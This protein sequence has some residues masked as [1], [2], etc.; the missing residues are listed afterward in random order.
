M[1]SQ[2][3]RT[4]TLQ[5]QS[6]DGY[7]PHPGSVVIEAFK[8]LQ[9]KVKS[10]EEERYQACSLRDELKSK[11]AMQKRDQHLVRSKTEYEAAE[12]LIHVRS[13]AEQTKRE[14]EELE[15]RVRTTQEVQDSI[16]RKLS[17]QRGLVSSLQED[18]DRNRSRI[19]AAEKQNLLL[20]R[21][22]KV[23]SLR[24]S[25]LDFVK[26]H[27]PEKHA[28]QQHQVLHSVSGLEKK[29]ARLR[30]GSARTRTHILSL[31]AYI[32]LLVKVNG[33]LVETLQ[34]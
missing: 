8:D 25:E 7:S 31:E 19:L 11:L 5:A 26:A 32:A 28:S 21:E 27:S 10:M 24:R 20:E 18:V 3:H 16:Q 6:G 9:R 33:D 22:L 2:T 15:S 34:T 29:I 14:K 12:A 23:L 13:F 30:R 1:F 17:A 4:S